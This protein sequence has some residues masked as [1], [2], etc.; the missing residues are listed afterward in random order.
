MDSWIRMRIYLCR[1][2][3]IPKLKG[4]GLKNLLIDSHL[5]LVMVGAEPLLQQLAA[6][7]INLYTP[8]LD[9]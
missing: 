9:E 3:S 5:E 2:P 4:V 6:H 8:T 7:N 1:A